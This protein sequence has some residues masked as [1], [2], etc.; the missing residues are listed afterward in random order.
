MTQTCRQ[1]LFTVLKQSSEDVL[2]HRGGK[3]STSHYHIL[4]K[5][6]LFRVVKNWYDNI[7]YYRSMLFTPPLPSNPISHQLSHREGFYLLVY[8][9]RETSS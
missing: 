6:S 2:L 8:I 5:Q 4:V 7:T 3:Y 9:Q 1:Y